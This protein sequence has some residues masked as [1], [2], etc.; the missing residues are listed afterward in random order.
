MYIYVDI[1]R[2]SAGTAGGRSLRFLVYTIILYYLL[3]KSYTEYSKK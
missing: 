1:F 3:Y 2:I